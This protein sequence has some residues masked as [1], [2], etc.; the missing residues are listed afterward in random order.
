ML[1]C[2]HNVYGYFYTMTVE[3][4]TISATNPK[5]FIILSFIEKDFQPLK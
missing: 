1:L 5:I 4:W 3:V 2:L